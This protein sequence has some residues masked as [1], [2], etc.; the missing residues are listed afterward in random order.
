MAKRKTARK[1]EKLDDDGLRE[2]GLETAVQKLG[3]AVQ[4][5]PDEHLNAR[6]NADLAAALVCANRIEQLL[7]DS[8]ALLAIKLMILGKLG[9]FD[10]ALAL[11]RAAYKAKPNWTTAIATANVLR[12]KGDVNAALDMFRRAAGH[13]RKDVTALLD[14]GDLN[15]K[16]DRW[17]AALKDYQQALKREKDHAWALPSTFYCRYRLS[18]DKRWLKKLQAFAEEPADECG[19]A[20]MLAH[21]FGGYSPD[22]RRRRAQELLEWCKD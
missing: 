12:R 19:L 15:L 1:L 22:N 11:A 4:G 20:D 13:D 6:Q 14:A 21:M 10:E 18:G 5:Y 7:G 17:Q 3:A 9:R 2:L 16:N 8:D